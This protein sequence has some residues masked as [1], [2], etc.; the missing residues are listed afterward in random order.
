MASKSSEKN[1]C[2]LGPIASAIGCQASRSRRTIRGMSIDAYD[3]RFATRVHSP[4]RVRIRQE[5][6]GDEFPLEA[7]GNNYATVSELGR[8]AGEL[9]V[10][11]GQTIVDLGLRLRRPGELGLTTRI[12]SGSWVAPCQKQVVA[13]ALKMALN[14]RTRRTEIAAGDTWWRCVDRHPGAATAL[15]P[16]G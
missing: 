6:Y 15:N 10:G 14:C 13:G 5:V 4:T 1:S 2:S 3:S 11:P 16:S 12:V 7:S 9:R 8:M